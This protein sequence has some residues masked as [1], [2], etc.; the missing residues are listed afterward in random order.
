MSGPG[1]APQATAAVAVVDTSR[2]LSAIHRPDCAAAIW[3]R[4][5]DP[6][7]SDWL[8]GLAPAQ[9]PAAR[10][11]LRPQDLRAALPAICDRAG[12]PDGPGR[13]R[14]I[15]DIALLAD[16]FAGLMRAPWLRLRLDVVTTDACRKFHVDAVMAR[17]ICTYRGTGTQYGIASGGAAPA[18]VQTAPAGAAVILRGSHWPEQPPSGLRH[19]SP[20]IAGTGETRLLL[21]LDPVLDRED[22]A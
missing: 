17:L 7:L 14:L 11:I 1:I 22:A 12:T 8:A 21:V 10:E 5:V 18:F 15:A 20:P 6:A 3:R 9:L 13:A 2:A 19:R 4:A 16:V